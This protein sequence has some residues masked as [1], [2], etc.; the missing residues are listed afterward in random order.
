MTIKVPIK[1][2]I[3]LLII[4]AVLIGVFSYVNLSLAQTDR[5]GLENA[6]G[7]GLAQTDLR[8][9]IINIIRFILGFLGLA[10]VIIILYGGYLWLTAAGNEQRVE[11]AKHVIQRAIIGVIIILGAVAITNFILNEI[12]SAMLE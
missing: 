12:T 1:K 9:A 2:I 10:A 4:M 5:F 6:A 8:I 7:I 3:P 11:E